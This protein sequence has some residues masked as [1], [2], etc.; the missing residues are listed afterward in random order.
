MDTNELKKKTVISSIWSLFERF[1]YL[2]CQFLSNLVLAR[3]LSPDDFGTIGL[4][5]VFFVLSNVFIDSGL[6]SAIIQKANVS[7]EDK[8]TVFLTNLAL[9][10]FV[11][12]LIFFA[13]PYVALYFKI[14]ELKTLLRVLE[15]MVV[16]DA[17]C[18]IQNA[19]LAREMNFKRLTIIKLVSILVASSVAIALAYVG[20]GIWALVVQYL[21]NSFIRTTITWICA[22]WYPSLVF[23]KE[24]FKTLFGYGSKLL[25]SSFVAELYVNLQQLLIGR[26]YTP[27][28]L[29]Y[30]SQARQLQNI[31]TGTITRV[32]NGVA[33]PA[34]AKLQNKRDDL[35]IMF[36][37]NIKLVAFI[38]T[39]LM[40][41]LSVIAFPLLIV[42]YSE[43]WVGSVEY[44]QFLCLAFGILLAMHECT[45]SALKAV[46]R[47]DYVL[48]L[49]IIKKILGISLIFIGM[50]FWGIWGI[51]YALGLNSIIEL[52]LN[53]HFLN[54]ELNYSGL[55]ILKDILPSIV[56]SFISGAVSYL[57]LLYFLPIGGNLLTIVTTSSL[58]II[59]YFFCAWL[60]KV[61]GFNVVLMAVDKIF[62]R[63][64][65]K[66]NTNN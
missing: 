49:E 20:F 16:I 44:F 4:L 42:L 34:Y 50:H 45:L 3:L 64:K 66:N 23:R 37:Q 52:F 1:G 48:R 13:A 51:L 40:V 32:I 43:K 15:L 2:T 35:Q 7:E 61:Y 63:I 30:Y 11:Y 58:F 46:G 56:I 38:N 10:L 8:S 36:R 47:S 6:S 17:F 14:P 39:P 41:L 54:K 55:G 62:E 25:L 33:F 57:F 60:M 29:G 12:V 18:S 21:L 9:A 28:D 22:K 53:G 26:Y 27:S 31:P 65:K 24:S 59:V 19:I 5:M